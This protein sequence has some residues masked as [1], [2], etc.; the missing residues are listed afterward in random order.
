MSLDTSILV[1]C[2]APTDSAAF[3]DQPGTPTDYTYFGNAGVFGNSTVYNNLHAL[4]YMAGATTNFI[5]SNAPDDFPNNNNNLCAYSQTVPF[6][7]SFTASE[8]GTYQIVV[9]GTVKGNAA[10]GNQN[11]SVTSTGTVGRACVHVCPD[12]LPPCNPQ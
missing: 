1:N 11:F 4:G 6:H 10:V 9:A 2:G 8:E 3:C 5:M 12:N 7:G